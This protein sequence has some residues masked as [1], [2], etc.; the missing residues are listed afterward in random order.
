MYYMNMPSQYYTCN[1]HLSENIAETT[2]APPTD[3]SAGD[4]AMETTPPTD[5]DNEQKT[6]TQVT[7][8]VN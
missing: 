1:L 6:E 5:Q 2:E 8:T 3:Q 4:E 7:W